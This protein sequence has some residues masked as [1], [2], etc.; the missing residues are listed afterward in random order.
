MIV[1]KSQVVE[2]LEERYRMYAS[3]GFIETDPI[4]IPHLFSRKEDI[5]VAGF[6]TASF[7]WGNRVSIIKSAR[8]LMSMMDDAPFD[9]I[10]QSS[11]IERNRLNGFV[12][13]TF[14]GNDAITITNTLH[15]FLSLYPSIGHFFEQKY[16]EHKEMKCVLSEFR[17]ELIQCGLNGHT[18]KHVAD[19]STGSAAKRLNMYLRWMVRKCEFDV[20]FGLWHT[21]PSSALYLPLDVHSGT[22][23]RQLGLLNRKQN[24]WKAVDEITTVL[25]QIDPVDPIRFDFAL[26]GLGAFAKNE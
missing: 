23:A 12:Y 13:R 18:L 22:I 7:A 26:F 25:R 21:I 10:T 15:I 16:S 3:M 9:F 19:V 11:V 8:K 24:D 14:N 4:Q 5:E 6:I 1:D 20:D 2:L 17:K